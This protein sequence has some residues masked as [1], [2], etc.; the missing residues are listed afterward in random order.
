M[1]LTLKNLLA[2]LGVILA[3]GITF[4]IVDNGPDHG[5]DKPRRTVTIELGGPGHKDV[6]IPPGAQSIAKTQAKQDAA[7]Q[8]IA[9]ESDLKAESPNA[10]APATLERN[11]QVAPAD[12]PV[13]PPS[14]PLA[15]QELP[16]C[17]TLPVRN[18]SSRGGKPV[19]LGVTHWTAGPDTF[20]SWNG[21]LGNVRWFDQ[22]ASQA[23]SSEIMD[24]G[25]Q[26]ALT[27][28]E[29]LKP[30][31]QSN[32]NG[33]SVSVE[34]TN[35]GRKKPLLRAAGLKAL[36]R[37]YVGWH[38]RW[39]IPL[40]RGRVYQGLG[41]ACPT[42]YRPGIVEHVDLGICGGG[43]PDVGH[44]HQVDQAISM[45]R[46]IVAARSKPTPRE[47][48]QRS[49]KILHAKIR[50]RCHKSPRPAGCRLLYARL[51]ALHAK[52]GAL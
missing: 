8:D 26:C 41:N 39:K 45:A 42:V 4:T 40:Q 17:R 23:S 24:S 52:Y 35:D 22:G 18:Y 11:E 27:V 1:R 13:V 21:I 28:P 29:A 3:A 48:A 46:S 25:G 43:H 36:A 38:D 31:T 15:S 6:A 44:D 50:Q 9:A 16:G 14:L 10:S 19:L 33:Y 37:L 32:Y 34:I 20:P 30:W 7:G 5:P 49:H 47:Q 12:A 51:G 2:V